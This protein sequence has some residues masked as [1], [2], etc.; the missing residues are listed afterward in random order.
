MPLNL[1][2]CST[3][4]SQALH[5]NYYSMLH[6]QAS[7]YLVSLGLDFIERCSYSFQISMAS[8]ILSFYDLIY[9][10]LSGTCGH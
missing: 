6:F 8:S 7:Y 3:V 5:K 10:S 4:F 2:C 9:Y 1:M